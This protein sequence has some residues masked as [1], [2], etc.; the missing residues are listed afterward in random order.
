MT[1]SQLSFKPLVPAFILGCTAHHRSL[2][3]FRTE[4]VNALATDLDL[5][6]LDQDVANPV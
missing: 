4:I 5:D 2:V 3:L 6:V 1:T